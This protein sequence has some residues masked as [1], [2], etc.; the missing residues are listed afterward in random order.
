MMHIQQEGKARIARHETQRETHQA[1]DDDEDALG[2][3]ADGERDGMDV[4]EGEE[5]D[6]VVEVVE[7]AGEQDVQRQGPGRRLQGGDPPGK[8]P[9][10]AF[11][12]QGLRV[13]LGWVG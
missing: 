5:H 11:P 12:Q 13:G 8:L 1:G 6:L 9:V 7:E 4:V 10:D 2:R 3:V